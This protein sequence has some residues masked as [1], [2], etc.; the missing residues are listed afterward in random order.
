M[1]EAN[2]IPCLPGASGRSEENCG[3]MV[4][5]GY[6]LNVILRRQPTVEIRDGRGNYRGTITTDRAL[7][8]L[9]D[10]T[11]VGVGTIERVRYLRQVASPK[12]NGLIG[13]DGTTTMGRRPELKQHHPRHCDA[14]A[15]QHRR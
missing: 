7:K 12:S 5:E 11:F 3:V 10:G 13:E 15:P 9:I 4:F 1:T 2:G 6:T 14:Y 8:L